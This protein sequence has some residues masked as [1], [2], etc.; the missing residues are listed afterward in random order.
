MM[1][2]TISD[3]PPVTGARISGHHFLTMPPICAQTSSQILTTPCHA[4]VKNPATSAAALL[5]QFQTSARIALVCFQCVAISTAIRTRAVRAIIQGLESPASFMILVTSSMDLPILSTA[6]ATPTAVATRSP[7]API[8]PRM[9]AASFWCAAIHDTIG[10]TTLTT[11][12]VI[13]VTIGRSPF[14]IAIIAVSTDSLSCDSLKFIVAWTVD[15]PFTFLPAV[16]AAS[17]TFA[18]FAAKTFAFGPPSISAVFRPVAPPMTFARAAEYV[19]A[20][21][22]PDDSSELKPFDLL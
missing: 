14:P 22:A 21:G 8:D 5:I 19:C 4:L 10:L 9:I 16:V 18:T 17:A 20:A 12:L 1:M 15:Q 13:F 3:M 11:A 7:S 2:P 6:K